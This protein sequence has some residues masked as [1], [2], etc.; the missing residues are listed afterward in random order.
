MH[1]SNRS[2]TTIRLGRQYVF[3]G[4]QKGYFSDQLS[5]A[6]IG[7]TYPMQ[8]IKVRFEQKE[9]YHPI[10]IGVCTEGAPSETWFKID[11]FHL[12]RLRANIET[13]LSA[14]CPIEGTES[15]PA[16][17]DLSGRRIHESNLKPHKIY[18]KNRKK[19]I[20]D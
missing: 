1:A 14:L 19:Y 18:I 20:F 6:G 4:S 3:A 9:D 8:T 13:G 10:N 5:T 15:S 2:A 7:D 17:Y 11:N 16:I 12:Y